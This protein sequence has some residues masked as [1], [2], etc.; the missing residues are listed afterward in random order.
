MSLLFLDSL[1]ARYFL[2]AFRLPAVVGADGSSGGADASDDAEKG[3]GGGGREGGGDG[4]GGANSILSGSSISTSSPPFALL[5]AEEE[6]EATFLVVVAEE[7]RR[8][9]A[10]A[11]AEAEAALAPAATVSLVFLMKRAASETVDTV[12]L[13]LREP[14]L[15]DILQQVHFF[16]LDLR[17]QWLRGRVQSIL[18]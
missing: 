1:C 4:G 17:N 14:R 7:E 2:A 6:E 5:V 15:A 13:R 9:D 18:P 12:R 10:E 8:P 3:G 16:Y 11:D